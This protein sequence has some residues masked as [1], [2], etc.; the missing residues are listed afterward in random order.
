MKTLNEDISFGWAGFAIHSML[1][2]FKTVLKVWNLRFETSKK[3]KESSILK[4][5]S[6]IDSKEKA[7]SLEPLI[8]KISL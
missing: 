7:G 2:N 1:Q 5:I 4:E 8:K 3:E 6:L